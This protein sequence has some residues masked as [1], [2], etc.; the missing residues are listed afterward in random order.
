MTDDSKLSD[1]EL[2][3]RMREALFG[4]GGANKVTVARSHRKVHVPG[5]DRPK[6]IIEVQPKLEWNFEFYFDFYMIIDGKRI[7]T[8][9][10]LLEE[11]ARAAVH[12]HRK[13]G[14]EVII[15]PSKRG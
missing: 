8:K 7:L 6:P 2:E 3:K 15:L 12:S 14:A 9:A 10:G 5:R 13:D 4:A 11:D 1:A